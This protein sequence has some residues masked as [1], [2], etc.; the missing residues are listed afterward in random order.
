MNEH[1]DNVKRPD[2]V[3]ENA[4]KSLFAT[5]VMPGIE[6]THDGFAGGFSTLKKPLP[7][8]ASLAWRST[9]RASWRATRRFW[10]AP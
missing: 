3:P 10:R 2:W 9:R 5:E 1:S 4:D 8:A 6:A 7:S